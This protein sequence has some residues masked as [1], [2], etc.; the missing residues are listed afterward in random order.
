M[1]A[2]F[3][4]MAGTNWIALAPVPITATRLP[5]GSN[6]SS[7][8][9]EWNIGPLKRS[10]P[11]IPGIAGAREL[12][13]GGDQHLGL[14][15]LAVRHLEPPAAGLRVEGRALHVGVEANQRR[16]AEPVRDSAQVC[17]DLAPGREALLQS[18]FGANDSE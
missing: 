9:A 3:G 8:W 2:T 5:A 7:Q 6:A 10:S 13:A 4:A 18:G 15:V 1:C 12:S 14:D 16:D 11:V 17:P